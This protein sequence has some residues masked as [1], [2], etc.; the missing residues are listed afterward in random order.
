MLRIQNLKSYYGRLQALRGISLHVGKGEIVT[1]IGANGAG[2]STILNTVAGIISQSEGSILLDGRNI[3]G[4]PPE[5]IVKLGAVLVPEGRQL[6]AP[7]SVSDNLLLGAYLRYKNGSKKELDQD[8]EMVFSL[9]PI[10]KERKSQLAGTLSGGEQQ[11]LAIGRALMSRPRL[12][13]LDEP[14][15]G[16]APKVA[17][18]IFQT[19]VRLKEQD[20]TILL[21]EQNARMALAVAE[22]GYVI[23]TGQV[24]VQGPS[25]DLLR[26]HEVERAYLGKTYEK[27]WE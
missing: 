15:M 19:I 10:L 1:L 12:M 8:L 4:L 7:M 5:K 24:V 3:R 11:M 20:V 13:L 27:I 2:K 14:S 6:F 9:F 17:E 22:R 18:E 26:N 16:L 23:E 21:V 25:A